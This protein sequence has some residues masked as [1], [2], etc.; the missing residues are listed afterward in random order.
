M[1]LQPSQRSSTDE[2]RLGVLAM[3]FRRTRDE[4]ARDAIAGEYAETVDR[5]IQAGGWD[6][7]PAPENLLP[8]ERMPQAFHEYWSRGQVAPPQPRSLAQGS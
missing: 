6:E 4:V 3:R 2:V 1:S 5:L 8:D 7:F